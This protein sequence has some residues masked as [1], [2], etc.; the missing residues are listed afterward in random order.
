MEMLFSGNLTRDEVETVVRYRAAHRDTILGLPT[1]YGYNSHEVAGFLTY[2]HA[3]GLL[4]HDFVPEFLLALYSLAAHQYTRGTWTAPETRSLNPGV[5]AAPYA[6]PAQ[7]TVPLLLRWLLLWEDPRSDTIWLCKGAPQ[8]WFA[9]GRRIAVDAAPTRWGSAGFALE[10]GADWVIRGTASLPDG[11]GATLRLRLPAGRRLTGAI[12]ASVL[13]SQTVRLDG[14]GT[15]TV[16][17]A[18]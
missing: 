10:T 2:G 13:D 17:T 5:N 9:P 12:G 4:Q 6:V 8:H 18:A 15:F 3:Y 11:P 7:L 14:S 16:S 1:A